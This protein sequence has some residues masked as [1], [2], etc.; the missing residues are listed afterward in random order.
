[1]SLRSGRNYLRDYTAE[2]LDEAT[3]G[4][5]QEEAS[6]QPATQQQSQFFDTRSQLSRAPSKRSQRSSSTTSSATKAYAKAKAA[7]AQLA[8]AEK[9]A[10]MMKQRAELEASTLKQKADLDASLH[11]LN[12]QKAAATAE[13]EAIAYEEAEIQ[14]GEFS[15]PQYAEFEPVSAAQRTSEYVQEQSELLFPNTHHDAV[16]T[17]EKNEN[18]NDVKD[19][20]QIANP[21][22]TNIQTN[23]PPVN[24]ET[25]QEPTVNT[26]VTNTHLP[27]IPKHSTNLSYNYM[28][29]PNNA[30]EFAKYL[31]RKELVST[32][33]LQYDDKPENYWAWKT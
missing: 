16:E 33:L 1:M 6:P 24:R 25:K 29:E 28:P 2:Q 8:F 5:Q 27:N 23:P 31:I 3:G 30:Q 18:E 4:E 9:E 20:T 26:Y 14:S 32:G 13:A 7:Q 17:P 19:S 10:D 12:C 21:V 11:L 15:R 22:T